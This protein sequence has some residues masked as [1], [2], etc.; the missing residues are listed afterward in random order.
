MFK[1]SLFDNLQILFVSHEQ[2][3]TDKWNKALV[4]HYM[5]RNLYLCS[6]NILTMNSILAA[7]IPSYKTAVYTCLCWYRR[8]NVTRT[9][10]LMILTPHSNWTSV[11][12]WHLSPIYCYSFNMQFAFLAWHYNLLNLK[13]AKLM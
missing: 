10:T 5:Y 12:Y 13:K 11:I 1:Y 6:F 9:S 7:L 2:V 3:C 4:I 8:F